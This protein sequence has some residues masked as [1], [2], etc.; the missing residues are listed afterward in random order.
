MHIFWYKDSITGHLKQVDALLM[1]LQKEVRFSLSSI[2][3]EKNRVTNVLQ[4][5]L[6]KDNDE[7]FP[8]VLIGAGHTVYPKILN[9]QK[10]IK[11]TLGLDSISIAIMRPSRNMSAFDLIC[12]PEHDFIKQKT[13][14]N[15]ITYQGA[16]AS[17]SFIASDNKKAII[18]IGGKSKHYKF[19]EKIV[20]M[21]LKY[22][23][24]RIFNNLVRVIFQINYNDFTNA[25]KV[26]TKEAIEGSKPFL[27]NHFNLTLELPLNIIIRGYKYEI[28]PN[29]WKNR[30]TGISKMKIKEMG[31]RYLFILLYCLIEK[32]LT[33]ND[34]RKN[35]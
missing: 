28:A 18:A 10:F 1:Q 20:L 7:N 8:I 2:D 4:S 14:N 23:L 3:C 27:S 15:V 30:K 5:V 19:D 22:V 26:Y 34:Y 21:Q 12:A 6:E 33:K 32:L 13:P 31:S 35:R 11:E 17:P 24:N 29:S 25:F 9:S 16:L